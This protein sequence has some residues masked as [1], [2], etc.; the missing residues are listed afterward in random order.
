MDK[1]QIEN[2]LKE[3]IALYNNLKQ[4][5]F[6]LQ[7]WIKNDC[8]ERNTLDEFLNFVWLEKNEESRFS[9]YSRIVDLHEESLILYLDKQD[10]SEDEK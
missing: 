9:A 1:E 2:N 3:I 10:F 7:K 5:L 4:S 8:V 6:D